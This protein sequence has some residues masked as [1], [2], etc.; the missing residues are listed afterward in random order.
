MTD[1]TAEKIEDAVKNWGVWY[2]SYH[3][4]V[5]LSGDSVWD[6]LWEDYPGLNIDIDGQTYIMYPRG[7]GG[8]MVGETV[9]VA[10]RVGNRIFRRNGSYLSHL[11]FDW[12]CGA[13]FEAKPVERT[14]VDYVEIEA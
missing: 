9:W 1:I 4:K 12:D 6:Y 10:F 11:G 5:E 8:E 2:W 13:L 14:Y 7:H 3:S